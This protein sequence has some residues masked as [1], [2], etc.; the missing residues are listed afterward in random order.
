MPVSPNNLID[1]INRNKSKKLIASKIVESN[2]KVLPV[3]PKL[4]RDP[5]VNADIEK[6]DLNVNRAILE[7]IYN[8][9]KAVKNNNKNIIKLFP[10]IELAIQII[11]SS[12][13]SPKKMTDIQLNYKF[14]KTFNV[15]PTFSADI[16]DIV[17]TYINDHYE[18][19]DKLSDIVREALF[20][21]G[22]YALAI[23]PESSVDEVINTDILTNYS[24][25]N[26]KNKVDHIF[27]KLVRPVNFIDLN[28]TINLETKPTKDNF[29]QHIVSESF[30]NITDNVNILRFGAIKEKI[31]TSL[32]RSS[33]KNGI[34]IASES[35]EKINYM[36]IFRT[37]QS[38]T[39]NKKIEFIK[40]KDETKRKSIGKPMMTKIPTE[41]IV[42][43]FIPGNETEHIGYFILLDE[44]GKPLNTE[45]KDTNISQITSLLQPNTQSQLTPVQKA[46][47]NLVSDST[48][49]INVNELFEMYKDVLEKQLYT[50]I[51]NSL[52]GNNV[53]LSNKN[54]IY[55][56]MFTRALADQKTNLLFIPKELIIYFAFYYNDIGIGKTLLE[57]LSV[58]SS[59]RAILLF[60][61]VMAYAKQSIDVTKV[62]ISLD[63]NDP[64]PEKTI[65]QIQ[66]SVLKLRQNYFPLG[67]NNPVDLLN[68]IQKAGLQFS[69]ENNPLIPNVKIDFEN[70]NLTHTIPSSELEEDLRKQTIIALGLSPETIDNGFSPEF[71][72]TIVN[73]NILLSKRI[74]IYQ[75]TLI[76]HLSKFLNILIYNDEDLRNIIREKIIPI[77]DN[78]NETLEEEE[79]QL[80][81][82]DKAGFIEY[83]IDKISENLFIDL[84]KPENTNISNLSAEYDVY[85]ENLEKVIDSVISA[86]IFSEDIS[87]EMSNHIDTIKNIFKHHL[88]RK[89]MNDNSFYPEVL[90]L[91]GNNEEDIENMLTVV[92][93][94]LTNTMKN[95]DKLLNIM[96]KFKEAVNKDL[97]KVTGDGSTDTS[98]GSSKTSTGEN[99]DEFGLDIVGKD[100]DNLDMFNP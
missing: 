64:D 70:A 96:Q 87:G 99:T 55:F 89:W 52:Y 72:T 12:I 39:S 35:M 61:K 21:S 90:N 20:T 56:L 93:E 80:L 65:E 76:K 29:I 68:W 78:L 79:K 59:L 28:K 50:S 100:D 8:R 27:D 83:Y 85:K 84:P 46:Y 1:V 49:N 25:E 15:N 63:P 6:S 67:I 16:I 71:A 18:I 42:P 43:V 47:S 57:N 3:I 14:N 88:L 94:H 74:A 33:L 92:T 24:T 45:I 7:D 32:V 23:I 4:I 51:K 38:V 86:E 66:D 2:P 54:D 17:K 36:D 75:K 41:S 44:G 40:N 11:V 82:K 34:S 26:F 58:L 62:N 95:S 97:E 22:A 37:K 30:I 73:N 60:A 98:T 81:A 53:E 13:L 91:V 48:N 5:S 31:T 69:Y 19:E 77:I 10:D 9:I